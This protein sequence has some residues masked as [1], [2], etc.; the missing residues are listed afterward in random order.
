MDAPTVDVIAVRFDGFGRPGHQ[1]SAA[2]AYLDAGLLDVPGVSMELAPPIEQPDPTPARG[3]STGLMNEKAL[4]A[5]TDE[6]HARVHTSLRAGRFPL[7]VGGDCSLLLG[8][9]AAAHEVDDRFGLLFADGH[10]DTTP[11]D[12][13]EDGEAANTELGLLLGVTGRRPDFPRPSVLS[14]LAPG[15][16]AAVGQRDLEWRRAL[17]IGSVAD[18][19]AFSCSARAVADDPEG[20]G[21]DAGGFLR[22]GGPWWLHV[23]LDVLDLA[24]LPA[25]TVPGDSPDPD[26]GGLDWRQLTDVLVTAVE[27][28][29]CHGLSVAIYDP[30][31]DPGH[32]HTARIVELM[33]A[34]VR[35][36]AGTAGPIVGS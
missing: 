6:L 16:L 25:T 11:L 32:R 30:E 28:G 14:V 31:L 22:A 4:L 21:R 17:N 8:T 23:D 7:V 20:V 10:E 15:R 2:D 34:L 27:R 19:G 24:V 26:G 5:L 1:A 33:H 12:V 36:R 3:P 18:L 35:A 29:G 13:S 9:F